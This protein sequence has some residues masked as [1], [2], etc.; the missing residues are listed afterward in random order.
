MRPRNFLLISLGTMLLCF[1]GC[2]ISWLGDEVYRAH[3]WHQADESDRIRREQW[4]PKEWERIIEQGRIA[5]Q[6]K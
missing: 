5:P 2:L 3:W 4:D 1:G 6:I